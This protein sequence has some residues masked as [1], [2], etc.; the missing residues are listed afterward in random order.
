ME[1]TFDDADFGDD[2]DDAGEVKSLTV[3]GE[4]EPIN[5]SSDASSLETQRKAAARES[6]DMSTDG[7]TAERKE[8][9]A[10]LPDRRRFSAAAKTLRKAQVYDA[11]RKDY[12]QP[13]QLVEAENAQLLLERQIQ[14]FQRSRHLMKRRRVKG[15]AYSQSIEL[16]VTPLPGSALQDPMLNRIDLIGNK[17]KGPKFDPRLPLYYSEEFEKKYYFKE[18]DLSETSCRGRG[19][20]GQATN[21]R[22]QTCQLLHIPSGIC[23]RAS[24]HPSLYANRKVA[25]KI[26]NIKLE[27]YLLGRESRS[28]TKQR[29]YL[30]Q[31]LN[32]RRQQAEKTA[33]ALEVARLRWWRF[34]NFLLGDPLPIDALTYVD[35]KSQVD[36]IVLE[37]GGEIVKRKEVCTIVPDSGGRKVLTER[38]SGNFDKLTIDALRNELSGQW[39]E[40]LSGSDAWNS[41]DSLETEQGKLRSCCVFNVQIP[42][43]FHFVFPCT[44]C[45]ASSPSAP[46][47][48]SC[49]FDEWY[50]SNTDPQTIAQYPIPPTF[51]L[52][53]SPEELNP[54]GLNLTMDD[55][56]ASSAKPSL[57]TFDRMM[58]VLERSDDAEHGEVELQQM[59]SEASDE[60]RSPVDAVPGNDGRSAESTQTSNSY[61]SGGTNSAES[62]LP[63]HSNRPSVKEVCTAM[64]RSLDEEVERCRN[65]PVVRAN[66][67]KLFQQLLEEVFGLIVLSRSAL[68][69]PDPSPSGMSTPASGSS[70]QPCEVKPQKKKGKKVIKKLVKKKIVPM[71]AGAVADRPST[72]SLVETEQHS[73]PELDAIIDEDNSSSKSESDGNDATPSDVPGDAAAEGEPSADSSGAAFQ[74]PIAIERDGL[75]WIEHRRRLFTNDEHGNPI[76]SP[77]AVAVMCHVLRCLTDLHLYEEKVALE[78]F[79]QQAITKK[80]ETRDQKM[81]LPPFPSSVALAVRDIVVAEQKAS[82]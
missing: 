42:L 66:V 35:R 44:A 50:V 70:A 21:R 2:L 17:P 30:E 1:V 48:N 29:Q 72:T 73:L 28:A 22:E 59:A 3:S 37:D 64:L 69:S 80:S 54:P 14:D 34:S 12:V 60:H 11:K 55:I 32:E 74:S 56:D 82:D 31:V 33:K 62:N 27:E 76:A 49:N 39:W 68:P 46:S 8:F 6:G 19:P 38:F 36:K 20:G 4:L 23:I 51:S 61:T 25:R 15:L 18:E 10:R 78:S 5:R 67:K 58:T 47:S 57:S 26:L 75:N 81:R 71:A 16:P 79:L 7:K 52:T 77:K 43:W 41:T 65:S 24:R 13:D 53:P 40:M 45:R 9:A 63:P